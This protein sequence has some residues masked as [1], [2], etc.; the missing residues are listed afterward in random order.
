[1]ELLGSGSK[2]GARFSTILSRVQDS[3]V[4]VP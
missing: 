2:F 4:F 1:M 3:D